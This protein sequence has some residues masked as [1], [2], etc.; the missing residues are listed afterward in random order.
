MILSLGKVVVLF[1]VMKFNFLFFAFFFSLV[2]LS[3][4]GAILPHQGRVLVSGEAFD[5]NASFRFALIEP[6]SDTI[7]WNHAGTTGVP[8]TDITLEVKNGFY[9]CSL[10]DTSKYGMAELLPQLFSYY[11]NL[12]LRVWFNDGVN[13]L[14]QLGSDQPLL[15]APYA[16]NS[17]NG[18]NS[19]VLNNLASELTSHAAGSG[20]SVNDLILRINQLAKNATQDG[21]VN[22]NMLSSNVSADINRTITREMLPTD[23]QLDLNKTIVITRDMLP[24]DVK[25]DLNKTIVIT[26]DM[27]PADVLSELNATIDYNRLS[28]Q[29]LADLN[30][31]SGQNGDSNLSHHVPIHS[32]EFLA[33]S[34]SYIF[35]DGNESFKE[36]ILPPA[37]GNKG[38]EYV[39]HSKLLNVLIKSL[40]KDIESKDY[41]TIQS[42]DG[43]NSSY[44]FS[45]VSDGINWQ[46]INKS[47]GTVMK[48]FHNFGDYPSDL[49]STT[50]LVISENMSIGSI[51][52][53]LNATDPDG[54]L[55]TYQ[56]VAG[57]GDGDNSLFQLESNG[58]L[59]TAAT[60]NFSSDPSNYSIRVQAK[61]EHNTTVENVFAVTLSNQSPSHLRTV[62]TLAIVENQPTGA[63]IGEF[64]ATDPEGGVLTYHLV[65]GQGDGNNQFFMLDTNGTL[66]IERSF[67]YETEALTYSIRV[68][69]KDEY[70]ASVESSFI[71]HLMDDV[72]DNIEATYTVS[73]GQGSPPYYNF[74]DGS[75][76]TPDFNNTTKLYKG[77][78]YEF[79]A[80]GVS[81]THPFMIGESYGDTSSAHVT[82]GP[83]NST[84]DGSKII[85]SIPFDYSGDFYF[86]CTAHSGMYQKFQIG[87]V[88]HIPDL[89]STVT[90]DMIWVDAGTFT[91]GSPTTEPGRD[92]DETEHN[93]S[94]SKGFYLG[95][96]EVTQAQYEAVM[97]GVSGDLNATPSSWANNANRPVERVSYDDIQVFLTRLNAQQ[98]TRIPTGWSYVLPT[99]SEWEY[100]CRAGTTTVYSWGDDINSTLANY[101]ASNISQTVN[102][103]QYSANSWGFFDMLGNVA[104]WTEDWYEEAYP[105]GNPEVDPSGPLTGFNRTKRGGSWNSGIPQ[106]RVAKRTSNTSNTRNANIGFRVA[107]KNTVQ[108]NQSPTDL[109][110]T[111]ALTMVENAALQ[112]VVGEF[113]A[114]D[115]EGGILTY[116]LAS[117]TGDGSNSLFLLDTNGT[118]KTE[119]TF[120]YESNASTYSIRVQAKD[121]QNA[122]VEGAFTITLTND[123]SD[124]PPANQSPADLN[125][126]STL[127]MVENAALQTVVGEFNATDPE[128][129]VLT[130]YLVSGTGDGSNSL[131]LLDTNGTLKTE[132]T[133]DYESNASTY[134]IR[135]QAKDDQNATVENAFTI[136]LT[137]VNE[138]P[139]DLNSTSTLTMVENAALQTVVGE[140]NATDP[141]GGVLTYYLVSGTGD[142]SNSLFLLDTNGTLKTE[143]TFDYES[144]AST[145]SIRV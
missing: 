143:A 54:G 136:I 98:S 87:T 10:G 30:Q 41:F 127:T 48:S 80:L 85:L 92:A 130:Y 123:P 44:S 138:Y 47:T 78:N 34:R 99:E 133:F 129:G 137:N 106:L 21:K 115:P 84:S 132:A 39:I 116:Y 9:K 140:F 3:I 89:N 114:T 113:S 29:I 112:T 15:N 20:I 6:S 94:I 38:K 90:M 42:P 49:N 53:V 81:D 107:F 79:V 63:I 131:F 19:D 103:G 51:V 96:Y 46:F 118:L 91:M 134:S 108:T 25:A 74:T 68:Q 122:T 36:L 16:L 23:V 95:K 86:Y 82:G 109:N 75:G 76:N 67:D 8:D 40:N 4:F 1:Q 128:G 111:S 58:T 119:A 60:F 18:A 83:F 22:H 17:G 24:A 126:T 35:L 26:R 37:T 62:S 93:V 125:S 5:G 102:A 120:D 142:G 124:D 105:T 33:I 66:K 121:D 13:G 101:Y 110:S 12:K 71:V 31:T 144:N 70:N 77:K 2:S 14:Q 27:L 65:S 135:V 73:G 145:Y 57:T 61:D 32:N 7:V 52:G 11:S 50:A 64:N 43:G 97:T 28:P 141:E 45:F 117:G 139:T 55:M 104:E 59:K 56:L 72:T 88:N 69:A 100:A